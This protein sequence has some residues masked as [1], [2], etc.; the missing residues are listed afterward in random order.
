LLAEAIEVLCKEPAVAYAVAGSEGML[1]HMSEV[2][3]NVGG[4]VKEVVKDTQ[5]LLQSFRAEHM[6]KLE[7]EIVR[8][9]KIFDCTRKGFAECKD[10]WIKIAYKHIFGFDLSFSK[11]GKPD[12][13][14]FHHDLMNLF[15]NSGVFEFA[16]KVIHQSG[17]YCADIIING[18]R[19]KKSFFPAEWTRE[20]VISKI[21]EV[22]ENFIKNGGIPELGP[23]GVYKIEN[24]IQEGVEIRIY[25]TQKG[26]VLTAYPILK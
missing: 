14:G 16:N 25:I 24:Y 9:R 3:T 26:K 1:H 15:E 8:L 6:A 18:K 13:G 19:F 7:P 10:K 2:A 11:K 20:K 5:V 4:T 17:F 12:F 23:N 21:Y 22:Y